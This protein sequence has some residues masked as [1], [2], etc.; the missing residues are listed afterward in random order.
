MAFQYRKN[1]AGDSIL[2]CKDFPLASSYAA[3]AKAGDVVKLDTNGQLVKAGT[4]DTAVLG[5]VEGFTFEGLYKQFK[6]GKVRLAPT[7]VYEADVTGTGTPKIGDEY[8]IDDNCNVD[9][10]DTTTKIVRVVDIVN[11]KP[12]VVFIPSALQLIN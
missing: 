7:A 4:S 9:L 12:Y 10:A 8:G 3:T 6:V 2:P 11:G 5:V 1:M